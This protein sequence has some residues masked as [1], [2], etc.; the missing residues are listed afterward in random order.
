VQT[1]GSPR[2]VASALA[3]LEE[4]KE[5]R[6]PRTAHIYTTIMG[7]CVRADQLQSALA[8][9]GGMRAEQ[10]EP[11]LVA[12][13]TLIDAYGQLRQWESAL[14]VLDTVAAK[15]RL[16]LWRGARCL[17]ERTCRAPQLAG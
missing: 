9:Y 8:V 15:V 7:L 4:M 1:A 3:L 17:S 16:L 11:S 13:H 12:Y 2:G 6:V 5:R 10:L 14:A